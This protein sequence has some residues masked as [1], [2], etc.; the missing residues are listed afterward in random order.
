MFRLFLFGSALRST[1]PRDIDMLVVYEKS[2]LSLDEA[3][4]LR[5]RVANWANAATGLTADVCLLSADED[6]QIGF[7]RIVG[8]TLIYEGHGMTLDS[9]DAELVLIHK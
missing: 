8:A 5:R 2:V 1:A 6:D 3:A 4:Q 9:L 7:S